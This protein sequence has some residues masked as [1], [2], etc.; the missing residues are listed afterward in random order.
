LNNVVPIPDQRAA[1]AA[2]NFRLIASAK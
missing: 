2:R 1:R